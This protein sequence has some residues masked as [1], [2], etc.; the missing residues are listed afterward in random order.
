MLLFC[1]IPFCF[2]DRIKI[3]ALQTNLLYHNWKA[4]LRENKSGQKT[5]LRVEM[6]INKS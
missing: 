6:R 2:V 1:V 5:C 3:S 4:G